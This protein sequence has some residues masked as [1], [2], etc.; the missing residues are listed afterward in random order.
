MEELKVMSNVRDIIENGVAKIKHQEFEGSEFP[1]VVIPEG[2]RVE[3]LRE[4]ADDFPSRVR[5]VVQVATVE[6]FIQYLDMFKTENTVI[7]A[8]E[9]SKKVKAIFDYHSKEEG[10]D[11]CDHQ[12]ILIFSFS[13][14]WNTW[15]GK[16][17]RR[18][19]QE[20]FALFIE[21]NLPDIVEPTG[22][23]MLEVARKLEATKSLTFKSGIRLDNGQQQLVF[24]EVIEG[25]AGN[26]RIE[27]PQEFHLGIEVFKGDTPYKVTARFRWR[28][29]RD[30]KS[31]ELWYD[32][33]RPHK[34]VEDAYKA[35]I[36]RLEESVGGKL[37]QK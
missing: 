4:I 35:A 19:G 28:I 37:I 18:F 3:S 21:D 14:E 33:V 6:S 30:T 8:N 32:L 10:A 17:G 34:I 11:W 25:V 29:K 24:D 16:N 31:L 26:G 2:C 15:A 1:F 23:E 13:P 12:L 20:D 7:F 27:I 5:E 36:A 9:D 22:L